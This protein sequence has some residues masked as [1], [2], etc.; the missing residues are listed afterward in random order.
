[1]NKK[2][3]NIRLCLDARFLNEYIVA[4]NES[5]P[6]I[7]ELLQ[8]FAG[9]KY[10]TATDLSC[11]YWQIRLEQSSRKYT[12]F[13]VNNALYQFCRVPFG[14]KTA[15]SAFITAIRAALG[16]FLNTFLTI[17]VDDLLITSETSKE[18]LNHMELL[19]DRLRE[20]NLRLKLNKSLFCRSEV[21]YL[22]VILS[23]E[24]I[25]PDPKKIKVIYNFPEPKSKTQLQQFIGICNYYRRFSM[26]RARFIYPFRNLL[27][28]KS[29]WSWNDNHREAFIRLKENFIECVY[30]KHYLINKK[31]YVQVDDMG[32]C[33]ILFQIDDGGE[34]RIVSL[35]SRTLTHC[36][37]HYTT[38]EKELLAVVYAVMKFR[39]YL[40]G[41]HFYVITDHKSLTFFLSI[42]YYSSRLVRWSLLLQQYTLSVIHCP[43]KENIVA[44][45][46]SRNFSSEDIL[47]PA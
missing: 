34:K 39:T 28:S 14:I 40:Y 21:P 46:F 19:F 2:D 37:L 20:H 24:G 27:S 18:H 5:P 4:D 16:T 33:G 32:I 47:V 6:I 30:L 43:G 7:E 35:V 3:G 44:D 15:S 13:L 10:F 26:S 29:N 45:F 8:K 41:V 38:T 17:Y 42:S 12:A 36:E 25:R 23:Q 22:G 11:G 1:M 9:V 31:F